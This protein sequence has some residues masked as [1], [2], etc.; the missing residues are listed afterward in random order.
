MTPEPTTRKVALLFPGQGAQHPR[1]GAD[2][3]GVSP[4]FTEIMDQAFD[5][6]GASGRAIRDDWLAAA[7]SSSYDDISRA[8][9]LLYAIDYAMGTLLLEAG[10]RPDVLLGHSVGELAAATLAGV[11]DFESGLRH[12]REFVAIYGRAPRGGM[13]AVAATRERVAPY[14]TDDVVVGAENGPRQLLLAGPDPALH[15][16]EQR[17]REDGFTCARA[18]ALQPFHSPVMRTVA[19]ESGPR[20]AR[21]RPRAPRIPVHSARTGHILADATAADEEFWREQPAEPVLFGP[22]LQRL[23]ARGDHLL[24]EAGP[25]QSLTA[26]ARR[27]RAVATGRSLALPTLPPRREHPGADLHMFTATVDQLRAHGHASRTPVPLG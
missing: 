4:R 20:E 13:L 21:L 10:V 24:V 7:P 16:V 17:L 25:G 9:P 19:E 27:T 15:D 3:Y 5:A 22:A 2:L 26:L 12:L 14:L 11:F 8:Q 23:L 18:R 6:F 1:M